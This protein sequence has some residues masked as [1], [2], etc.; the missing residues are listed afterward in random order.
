MCIN[1]GDELLSIAVRAFCD[2]RRP[3]AYPVPTYSLYPVLAQI[4]NVKAIELGF[5]AG[6]N[7]PP[8]L[9]KTDAALTIVCNPNAPS[10][11]FISSDEMAS[12]ADRLKGKQV[13][14]DR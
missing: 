4:E 9:A 11:S 8:G 12:L 7:L 2:E 13:L 6:Y 10:G 5:D 14:L 1:G 3:L